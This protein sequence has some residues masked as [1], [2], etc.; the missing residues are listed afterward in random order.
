MTE[1][2]L[3]TP[4]V[5]AAELKLP[6]HRVLYVLRTRQHIKP[7]A[8]AGRLRLYDGEAMAQL[9]YEINRL[10]ARRQEAKQ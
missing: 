8:R 2:R 10:E 6:L 9:R 5:I 1:T 7:V 4:G 3:R